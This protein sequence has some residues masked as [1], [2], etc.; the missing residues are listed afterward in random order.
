[1]YL[2]L[3]SPSS[4]LEEDLL[5]VEEVEEEPAYKYE[6]C[7]IDYIAPC[8]RKHFHKSSQEEVPD[9]AETDYSLC[10]V[11][12]N[13]VH[14]HHSEEEGPFLPSLDINDVIEQGEHSQTV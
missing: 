9:A 2:H 4:D 3:A 11:D 8:F 6:T 10:H 7:V 1:M 5:F 12:G 13:G 14:S